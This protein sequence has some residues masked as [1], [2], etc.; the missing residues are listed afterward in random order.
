VVELG[1]FDGR[2]L[3][4]IP[5][6]TRY[7]GMD[8]NWE[9]G[10]DLARQNYSAIPGYTFLKVVHPT[11]IGLGTETF[12]LAVSLETLEHIPPELVDEF[13]AEIAERVDYFIATVPN[14]IGLVFLAK[15][16]VKTVFQMNPEPYTLAEVVNALFGRTERVTRREHKG[17]NYR[18]LIT[19]IERHFEVMAVQGFPMRLPTSL[20]F[21]VGIV[22][23]RKHDGLSQS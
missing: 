20:C 2:L 3:D 9:G 7:V 14:E 17:F 8:A 18:R 4:F 12:Q 23:R 5:K 21:G 11:D 6:P 13:L 15:W 1:C 19:Q 10:L 22:S 16:I